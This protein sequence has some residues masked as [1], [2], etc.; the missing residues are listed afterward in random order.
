MEGVFSLSLLLPRP[1]PRLMSHTS[2]SLYT[3]YYCYNTSS[4][5]PT[6]SCSELLMDSLSSLLPM[7]MLTY[8]EN[9][10]R[11][12]YLHTYIYTHLVTC[13]HMQAHACTCMHMHAHAHMHM[14]A[15]AHMHTYT[16]AHIHTKSTYITLSLYRTSTAYAC[17]SSRDFVS[18]YV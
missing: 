14:H 9:Y 16:H 6:P 3:R 5:I 2:G 7:L 13:M 8:F 10:C 1:S 18:W 11:Q 12:T 15:H 17:M 4:A